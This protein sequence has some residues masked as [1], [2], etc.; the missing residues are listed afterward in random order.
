M[1]NGGT[2]DIDPKAA[3]FP[4][5]DMI[6]AFAADRKHPLASFFRQPGR[7][8]LRTRLLF[9]FTLSLMIPILAAGT[10]V[11]LTMHRARRQSL[12]REQ[13]ELSRR[14]ADRAAAHVESTRRGLAALTAQHRFA[15]ALPGQQSAA[16]RDLL[17]TYPDLMEAVL[18]DANGRGLTRAARRNGRVTW[19]KDSSDRSRREEFQQAAA[20]RSYIGQGDP[21]ALWSICHQSVEYQ[22]QRGIYRWVCSRCTGRTRHRFEDIYRIRHHP[23]RH[24]VARGECQPDVARDYWAEWG[25]RGIFHLYDRRRWRHGGIVL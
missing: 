4:A 23:R 8:G 1:T 21:L 25:D 17:E 3:P 24:R 6:D 20:G 9:F 22:R 18:Y 15:N 12:F 2:A 5:V 13:R 19:G 16:L 14:I 11:W 10:I 7:P